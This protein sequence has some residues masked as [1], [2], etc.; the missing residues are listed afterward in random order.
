MF[1]FHNYVSCNRQVYHIYKSQHYVLRHTLHMRSES[2][3]TVR[4]FIHVWLCMVLRTA[5]DTITVICTHLHFLSYFMF[6]GPVVNH[7]LFD[8]MFSRG[9][10]SGVTFPAYVKSNL[11]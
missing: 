2:D 5:Q 4:G 10:L 8:L 1:P 3:C 6:Y 11:N 7:L 9:L